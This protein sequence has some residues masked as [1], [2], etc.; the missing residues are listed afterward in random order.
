VAREGQIP[1]TPVR[2]L[3]GKGC[4]EEGELTRDRFATLHGVEG[5]PARRTAAPGGGHRWSNCSGELGRRWLRVGA[6]M[7][8]AWVQRG[9]GGLGRQRSGAWGR[10]RRQPPMAH[11]GDPADGVVLRSLVRKGGGHLNRH[12]GMG[13]SCLDVRAAASAGVH[14]RGGTEPTGGPLGARPVGR[15]TTRGGGN[16][17]AALGRRNASGNGPWAIQPA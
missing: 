14:S 7:D 10:A 8:L 17:E 12:Q 15:R 6:L 2:G 11:G 9:D 16:L 4:G 13:S 1:V 3:A 5:L